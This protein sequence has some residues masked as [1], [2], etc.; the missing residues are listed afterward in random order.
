MVPRN[1]KITSDEFGMTERGPQK[2]FFHR[3]KRVIASTAAQ[4]SD[5][6][7]SAVQLPKLQSLAKIFTMSSEIIVYYPEKVSIEQSARRVSF[8]EEVDIVNIDRFEDDDFEALFYCRDDF[9]RFRYNVERKKRR[10]AKKERRELYEKLL[11]E[12]I[13]KEKSF[14][15]QIACFM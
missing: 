12:E 5:H 6:T 11:R 7:K 8:E 1:R 2:E 4:N 14:L 3:G 9:R 15:Q 10:Q 13:G